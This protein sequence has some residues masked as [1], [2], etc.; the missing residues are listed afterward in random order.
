MSKYLYA[1]QKNDGYEGCQLLGVFSDIYRW[2]AAALPARER[3]PSADAI[4]LVWI[5]REDGHVVNDW[6]EGQPDVGQVAL[7]PAFYE[8]PKVQ[9]EHCRNFEDKSLAVPYRVAPMR[10]GYRCADCE[11]HHQNWLDGKSQD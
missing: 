5:D 10:M 8:E 3:H 2:L 4:E 9:C 6:L 1:L 11:K 7:R